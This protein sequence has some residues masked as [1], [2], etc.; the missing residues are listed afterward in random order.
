MLL[1]Y[2]EG[3]PIWLGD[4][5]SWVIDT[6]LGYIGKH[7]L[8]SCLHT[9]VLESLPFF[10]HLPCVLQCLPL[11]RA[12]LPVIFGLY[13][14]IHELIHCLAVYR[15]TS[16]SSKFFSFYFSQSLRFVSVDAKHQTP[17]FFITRYG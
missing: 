15:H 9:P 7:L 12:S 11:A 13:S 16:A 2:L 1:V 14:T 5:K 17:G 10:R 4:G 8:T 3:T 6:L